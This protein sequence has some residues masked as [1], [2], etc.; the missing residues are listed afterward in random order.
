MELGGDPA[1]VAVAGESAGGNLAASTAIVLQRRGRALAAQLLVVPGV[2]MARDTEALQA[3]RSDHPMLTPTDLRDI[4]RLYM[5]ARMAEAGAFPPS[6]L[7]AG[8][9]AGLPPAVI[10]LAGHDPLFGEGSAYAS[11]LAEAGVPVQRL[12]FG[13]MF[14]PFLGFSRSRKRREG[15]ATASARPS[16]IAWAAR[17]HGFHPIGPCVPF[18]ASHDNQGDRDDPRFSRETFSPCPAG[19]ECAAV[20]GRAGPGPV[21]CAIPVQAHTLCRAL[22]RG[23]RA[24]LCG[25]RAGR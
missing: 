20:R 14:H 2:D 16:R 4:T 9:L 21:P 19:R 12:C 17:R 8:S 7:R 22:C 24:G 3:R 18:R 6:P 23:R 5:G 11:R 1:R 13:D 15:P 25:A 10:A